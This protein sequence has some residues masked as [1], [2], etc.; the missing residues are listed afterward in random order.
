VRTVALVGQP[1]SGK[2]T[3][4]NAIARAH[5]A[6][7]GGAKKANLAMISVPDPRVADLARIYGSRKQ[8][9]AQVRVVDTPGLDARSVAEARES[10]AL[11]IVLRAFGDDADAAADLASLRTE[12][13]VTDLDTV[14]RALDRARR[15]PGEDKAKA[16]AALL[17]RA[18]AALSAGR[19]LADEDW[20]PDERRSLSLLTPLTL[21]PSLPVL[22]VDEAHEGEASIAGAFV[23]RGLLEAEASEL[24]EDDALALLREFGVSESAT[25]RFVHALYGL[26]DLVTYFTAGEPE[27]AARPVPRGT[28]ARQA[29]GEIHSDL[30]KGFIRA[31]VV[32][33]EDLMADGSLEACRER[34]HLRVEGRD[35]V[36]REGD[37]MLVRH[38]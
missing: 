17:E 13:T 1:Y 32:G 27:A 31:E 11:A 4:F 6:I 2:S 22:N 29:A 38:S 36:V 24:D 25:T 8:T 18:E 30:E 28:T 3:V 34:G 9:L 26:L 15:K 21:K 19:W 33:Y 23:I 7:G 20:E 10:D 14:E 12:L 16:E 35:Y 37:V 5:A